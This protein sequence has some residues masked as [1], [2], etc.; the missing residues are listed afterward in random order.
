MRLSRRDGSLQVYYAS[1]NAD[2]DQDILMQSST[3]NGQ[4]WS[5]PPITVAG[6]TTTGRDGMPGCASKY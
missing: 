3:D 4:T 5:S 6:G 2:D 1:E